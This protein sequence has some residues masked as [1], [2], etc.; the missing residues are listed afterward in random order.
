MHTGIV[1]NALERKKK[2]NRKERCRWLAVR[3]VPVGLLFAGASIRVEPAQSVERD[4]FKVILA[5]QRIC[6]LARGEM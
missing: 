2:M 4:A 3:A 1:A 6:R 5:C